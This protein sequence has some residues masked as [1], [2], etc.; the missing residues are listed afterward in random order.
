MQVFR[1]LIA[2]EKK[3]KMKIIVNGEDRSGSLGRLV[4][5]D[6]SGLEDPEIE[7][8]LSRERPILGLRESRNEA[9]FQL[10]HSTLL[11]SRDCVDTSGFS[12]PGSRGLLGYLSYTFRKI[13]WRL[14]RY[15]H[16]WMSFAQ[17]G[18]NIQFTH[19]LEVERRTRERQCAE[20]ERRIGRLEQTESQPDM[21]GE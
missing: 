13:M 6:L 7:Q 1:S 4:E 21:N 19:H 14:L 9:Q 2:R 20:L 18:V 10:R 3:T 12:T 16:D 8:R 15:Q 11:R 17:N 5:A